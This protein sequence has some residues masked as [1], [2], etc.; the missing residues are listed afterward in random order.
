MITRTVVN[1]V[2]S[3]LGGL[4]R[5]LLGGSSGQRVRIATFD[6]KHLQACLSAVEIRANKEEDVGSISIHVKTCTCACTVP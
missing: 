3:D 5:L 2:F 4:K 1:L 6:T